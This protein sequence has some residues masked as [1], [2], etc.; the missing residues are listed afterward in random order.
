MQSISLL[1]VMSTFFQLK[2]GGRILAT[3]TRSASGTKIPQMILNINGPESIIWAI[4]YKRLNG[5]LIGRRHRF[6]TAVK[7]WCE[8]RLWYQLKGPW[9]RLEGGWIGA[10][11]NF[12]SNAADKIVCLPNPEL[13]GFKSGTSGFGLDSRVNSELPGLLIQNFRVHSEQS[14]HNKNSASKWK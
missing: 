13:P 3:T 14:E 11:T 2:F 4:T 9:C 5:Y 8:V 1:F 6:F 10:P 7:L 12:H